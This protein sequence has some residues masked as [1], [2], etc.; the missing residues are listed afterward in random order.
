MG[1]VPAHL[2]VPHLSEGL[3]CPPLGVFGVPT[4]GDRPPAK[5]TM[6]AGHSLYHIHR[7]TQ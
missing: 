6:G 2:A 7:V 4:G 3:L 1:A 5:V